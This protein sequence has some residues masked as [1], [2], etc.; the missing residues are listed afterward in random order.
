MVLPYIDMDLP[1]VY[2]CSPSW[3]PLPSPSPSHPSRSS[4]CINPEHPV[5]CIEPGLAIHFTY[6]NIHVSMPFSQIIPPS[7]SPTESKR[8]FCTSV[9]LLLSHIWGYRYHLSR[10]HLCRWHKPYGRKWRGTKK[11][12]DESGEWKSWLKAQHS[13]NEDHGIWSHHFMGN[14]WGKSG[15]SVRLYC[16]GSKIT[17]W[18]LQLWN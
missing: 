4:Q 7:S 12:L 11:P 6:D 14:R 13:E 3:T 1:R 15:N 9:S 17:E 18:W 10:F 5:S 2:M 8:L 16:W